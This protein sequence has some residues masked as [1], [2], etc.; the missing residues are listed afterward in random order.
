MFAVCEHHSTT[1]SSPG[2][3][4]TGTDCSHTGHTTECPYQK[5]VG[6]SKRKILQKA[7]RK[8]SV[9]RQKNPKPFGTNIWGAHLKF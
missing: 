1:I 5:T 6:R 8:V 9:P 3:Q 4:S 7:A 2:T